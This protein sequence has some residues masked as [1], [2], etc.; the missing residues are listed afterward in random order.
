MKPLKNPNP[1]PLNFSL[2]LSQARLCLDCESIHTSPSCPTCGREANSW[3]LT[4]WLQSI[5][6]FRNL[7]AITK[8]VQT[9]KEISESATPL[10]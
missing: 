4:Y 3:N 9:L 10:F 5:V 2:P 1:V 7:D 8:R 6:P